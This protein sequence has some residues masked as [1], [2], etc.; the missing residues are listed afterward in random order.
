MQ[1]AELLE[2]L[3]G[4][5][6]GYEIVETPPVSQGAVV[7]EALQ[8]L[9]GF[10]LA[11]PLDVETIH[12][13]VEAVRLAFADR[14]QYLGDPRFVSFD[15][16]RLLTPGFTARRRAAIDRH[17]AGSGAPARPFDLAGD[18]T[19]FVVADGSG[20]AV[21]FIHSLSAPGGSGVLAGGILMNNRIGRGFTLEEGHPNELAPGKR[22]MHTLNCYLVLRDGVPCY[23]GGTPGGD[24]QPQWNVQVLC[25]LL[26]FGMTVQAAAEWPR[27]MVYP[28][29]DP[30]TMTDAPRLDLDGRF[31]PA[32]VEAL[33]RRGHPARQVGPWDPGRVGAAVQL[34]ARDPESGVLSAGSDPRGPGQAMAW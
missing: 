8:I 10:E 15:V 1:T 18:T 14:R 27:W 32:L 2:P 26:D 34:I 7:V 29:T 25:S 31:P 12:L 6:R 13:Q 9:D 21:S 17:R 22:T 28:A 24:G 11:G 19:S 20:W 16:A 30:A 5:Y 4:R 33:T 3:R 23:V